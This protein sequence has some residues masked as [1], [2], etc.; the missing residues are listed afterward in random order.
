[1][2]V[3]QCVYTNQPYPQLIFFMVLYW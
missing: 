1:M 3:Y 2:K